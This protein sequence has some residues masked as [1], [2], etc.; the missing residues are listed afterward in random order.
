V[1]LVSGNLPGKTQVA[2]VAIAG[3]AA[4]GDTAGAAALSAVLLAISL[5]ILFAIAMVGWRMG[6]REAHGG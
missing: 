1:V 4:A 6:K 5:V 3:R 2:S